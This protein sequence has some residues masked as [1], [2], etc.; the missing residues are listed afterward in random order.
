[1]FKPITMVLLSFVGSGVFMIWD[2]GRGDMLGSRDS[3]LN[4]YVTNAFETGAWKEGHAGQN[5]S[6]CWIWMNRIDKLLAA[7]Y[8]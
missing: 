1:M 6:L 2:V 7:L 5:H 3:R 4:K 8:D